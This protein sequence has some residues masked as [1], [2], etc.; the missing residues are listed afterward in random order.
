MLN[1]ILIENFQ[2]HEKTEID[3]CSGVNIIH[4]LSQAGKTAIFR[5][6]SWVFFNRPSGFRFHSSFAKDDFT[7]V[8]LLFDNCKVILKKTEK[9]SSYVLETK[10][11]IQEFSAIGS[12]VPDTIKNVLNISELNISSQL[13]PPFLVLNSP[14]EIGRLFNTV[15]NSEK[16]D[17]FVG[18]LTSAINKKK[19]SISSL[20]KDLEG[21]YS[22]IERIEKVEKYDK[23]FVKYSSMLEKEELLDDSI[24]IIKDRYQKLLVKQKLIL[25]IDIGLLDRLSTRL[26]KAEQYIEKHAFKLDKV[27]TSY[28]KLCAVLER[29][30]DDQRRLDHSTE[31]FDL[32]KE[33]ISKL[34]ELEDGIIK[35]NEIILNI[36]KILSLKE[37]IDN[38]T[39]T[40]KELKNKYLEELSVNNICPYCFSKIDKEKLRNSL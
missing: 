32:S 2:S 36:R 18:I 6:L 31:I 15:T 17:E 19:A 37:S 11:G 22:Q 26:E 20:E 3:L 12:N 40:L 38:K 8:T 27:T 39:Q 24:E 16:A 34:E 30:D 9:S 14:G 13:D 29:L 33:I 5:A 7:R 10:N 25:E 28:R 35:T 21:I 1:K 4:G 23:L